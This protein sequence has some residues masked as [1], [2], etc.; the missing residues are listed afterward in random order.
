VRAAVKIGPR[1]TVTAP[2]ASSASVTSSASPTSRA[3]HPGGGR[4]LFCFSRGSR[5]HIWPIATPPA[6]RWL[7]GAAALCVLVAVT[8]RRQDATL[9]GEPAQASAQLGASGRA[10]EHCRYNVTIIHDVHWAAAC[11]ANAREG[12]R[13]QAECQGTAPGLGCN[14]PMEP[15]DDFPDC[16]LPPTRAVALN[17]SRAA[18]ENR[19][20]DEA[21]FVERLTR[22]LPAER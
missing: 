4:V 17:N 13:I 6:A 18:A 8:A 21:A 11:E 2:P 3:A 15:P 20:F 14:A 12:R 16:T 10:L 22:T 9:V 1:A 19:C 5:M 7:A